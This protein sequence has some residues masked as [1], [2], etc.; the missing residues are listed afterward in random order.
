MFQDDVSEE[1]GLCLVE[2]TIAELEGEAP[3]FG[4]FGGLCKCVPY[5]L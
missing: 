5:V 2:F 1:F 4:A 3:I